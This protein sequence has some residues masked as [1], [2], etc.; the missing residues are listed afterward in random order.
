M[1]SS[2]RVQGWNFWPPMEDMK[3][4]PGYKLQAAIYICLASLETV[5]P[6]MFPTNNR[7]NPDDTEH[8]W[9]ATHSIY[10]LFRSDGPAVLA[11]KLQQPRPEIQP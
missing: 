9:L 3:K 11:E 2:R 6:G 8:I 1:Q 10:K 4:V 7:S 5:T